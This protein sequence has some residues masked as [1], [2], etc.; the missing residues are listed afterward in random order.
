M[1]K[2]AIGLALVLSVMLFGCVSVPNR[3]GNGISFVSA[4]S[5]LL[6]IS[7]DT[8]FDLVMFAGKVEH[9]NVLGG[10]KSRQTR[11]FDYGAFLPAKTGAFLC[12]AVKIEDYNAKNGHVSEDDTVF[13]AIVVYG[14]NKKAS[15]V[16]PKEIGGDG[17]VHISNKSCA[18]C[19]IVTDSPSGQLLTTIPAGRYT[20]ILYLENRGR[21][22]YQL[23]IR[24]VIYDK[25]H[26][27]V[28]LKSVSQDSIYARAETG[29]PSTILD[30]VP[31]ESF[32][33]DG[34][35]YANLDLE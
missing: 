5:G 4:S 34:V 14:N 24:Y 28:I 23:F 2:P 29:G 13:A 9:G 1:K 19:E 3:G 6:E 30:I 8:N 32:I 12:R 33:Q 16:I 31:P 25:T 11:L 21:R 35:T 15:I 22:P 18:L 10:I 17:T 7:N 27:E 26:P 20:T